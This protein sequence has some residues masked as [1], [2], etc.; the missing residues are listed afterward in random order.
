VFNLGTGAKT[1][2]EQ[3]IRSI[4]RVMGKADRLRI[5]QIDGTPGDLMGC[6]A[7]IRLISQALGYAPKHELQDGLQRMWAWVDQT[8]HTRA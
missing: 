2:F 8:A 6:V 5:D 4:A 7:D 3:L 1:T